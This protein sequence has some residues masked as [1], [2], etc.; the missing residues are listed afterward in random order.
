MDPKIWGPHAWFFMHSVTLGYPDKPTY[1]DKIWMKQFFESVGHVLPC[2]KCRNNYREHI[3]KLPLDNSVLLSRENHV[4]WLIDIH[5][6]VNIKNSKPV[7][8]HESAIENF[9]NDNKQG[10]N[11]WI[12]IIIVIIIIILIMVPLLIKYISK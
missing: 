2:M 4:K 9:I 10:Q 1:Q 3:N 7:V 11:P 12:C 6:E 5:N 8:T